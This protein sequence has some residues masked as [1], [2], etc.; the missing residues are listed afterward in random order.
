VPP[1]LPPDAHQLD[2][3]RHVGARV[4]SLRR[5]AGLTQ[6]QLAEAI[7][8]DRRAIG[9]VENGAVSVRLDQLTAI[10]R[11]IGVPVWRLLREE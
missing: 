2:V 1:I 4:L 9:R 6:E 8:V 7:Q 10:A 3:R 11:A 5:Q